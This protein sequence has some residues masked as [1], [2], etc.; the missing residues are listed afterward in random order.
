[1]KKKYF[2]FT[3][4]LI[5]CVI[6]LT[7]LLSFLTINYSKNT[8]K[9]D[10]SLDNMLA[11]IE[12]ISK[13]EHSVFDQENI[14]EVR[15]YIVN[16]LDSYGVSNTMVDHLEVSS[17][18]G[19]TEEYEHYRIKNIY[20]E[21]PGTSG[22]N[23][24]LL[25]HYDSSPYKVKYGEITN[26]SHG[27]FDDGYGISTLLEIARLYANDSGL[28]NGIKFA[29]LDAEEVGLFGARAVFS[30]NASWLEDVN[31]VINVESRGHTGPV[32]LF[33]TSENNSKMIE[34]YK[35]AGFPFAFSASSEVYSMMPNNTDLTPFI[36]NGFNC[37]NLATLDDLE[38]YHNEN[39]NFSNIDKDSVASYCNTILPLLEEY[40][41]DSKYSSLDY[42]DSNSNSVFFTLFPN[43]LVSYSTTVGW[44][45]IAISIVFALCLLIV[46]KAKKR[47]KL[48][49]ILISLLLDILM[50]GI[51]CGIGFG[52]VIALCKI[53]NVNYH[54][55]FVP[56]IPFDTG[57]L[58]ILSGILLLSFLLSS[59]LKSKM[60]I[61]KEEMSL[62]ATILNAVL[63]IVCAFVL[64]GGTFIFVLP[65]LLFSITLFM[66]L[67]KNIKLR[68]IISTI[69]TAMS[70]IIIAN[71]FI[72]VTYSVYV[73]LSFGALG[74][75]LVIVCLPL[76][77]SVPL[78]LNTYNTNEE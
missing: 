4:I 45:I 24:L 68:T 20:A 46:F 65:L 39:D 27:A 67:I 2:I 30:H 49:K 78:M 53:F 42:F 37:L 36:D 10:F 44:I 12:T 21:I 47:V 34:F 5:V 9:K 59:K 66:S 76:I 52:V 41:S 11:H 40:T 25:A 77:N 43:V 48:Y 28:A 3:T 60:K 33:E 19:E 16:T 57:I 1:M 63:C 14:E 50:L 18:N 61:N 74:V 15:Q 29:F 8:S 56:S 6:A 31:I 35:N 71:L 13:K 23:I 22:T 64:F 58:I 69:L 62:G 17:Y 55:M 7:T 70:S 75:L 54:F 38:Y 72:S 51:A 73:A 26:N 32:Y